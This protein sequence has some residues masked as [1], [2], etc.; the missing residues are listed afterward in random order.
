MRY[1]A[2]LPLLA[3]PSA[4]CAQC[5]QW[6]PFPDHNIVGDIN[7][8]Q[9]FE[10][11]LYVGGNFSSPVGLHAIRNREGAWE[12]LDG[13]RPN[14][15]LDL[16]VHDDG[17]GPHLYTAG[18]PWFP[19]TPI[20][21]WDG[22]AWTAINAPSAWIGFVTSYDS[23]TGP[24]LYASGGFTQQ[25]SLP[26]HGYIARLVNGAWTHVGGGM[27]TIAWDAILHD[28][29]RG[30]ALFLTG[31]FQSCGGI[32][33]YG[34]VRWDG[35]SWSG[36]TN[37]FQGGQPGGRA[38]A[39]YDDGS[40][41]AL[42]ATGVF[43]RAGG[44]MINRVAKWNGTQWSALGAGLSGEGRALAVF[45]D[46]AG[47]GLVVGGNF[48]TAGGRPASRIA[49]WRGGEWF[50]LSSGLNG[51]V[52]AL[53][54]YDLDGP[55]PERPSLIAA[56]F[57]DYAGG[58]E[59]R[60]I[61]RYTPCAPGACY[62]NCDASTAAPALNVADFTCFL[63]RF[64]AAD[65]YANCDGSTTAPMLNVADFTCFLQSFAQGCPPP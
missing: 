29:G 14:E 65:P 38:L 35:T 42:Y 25:G 60:I 28:D 5:A 12:S 8:L 61:A 58:N 24:Q 6:H 22:D 43:T 16:A 2:A 52:N 26:F 54:V 10:G 27:D 9:V 15:V 20:A 40:G 7:A 57:F 13:G 31:D 4:A 41:P 19:G 51:P 36:L 55:G 59:A 3:L 48:T 46:G 39:I 47:P 23:G 44:Q 64:A 50:S 18:F 45:D 17:Q 56:G 53:A 32:S 37:G 62:A 49:M 34:V 63:Q 1:A 30:P 33:Y 11:A 21:R